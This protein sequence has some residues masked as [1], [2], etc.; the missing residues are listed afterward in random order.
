[1]LVETVS[2]PSSQPPPQESQSASAAVAAIRPTLAI[3]EDATPTPSVADA[4]IALAPA[5]T[6][7]EKHSTLY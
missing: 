7:T 4:P 6:A 2:A 1:M 3:K 5:A